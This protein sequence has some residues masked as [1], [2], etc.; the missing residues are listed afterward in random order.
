MKHSI[1][2]TFCLALVFLTG[3]ALAQ[4][5]DA[6][7]DEN[8]SETTSTPVAHVYVGTGNQ[9]EAFSAAL[10]GKL[11][12]VP[13]SPFKYSLLLQGANDHYLFG[14]EPSSVII[15]SFAMAANGALKMAV[16]T[17][18]ENFYS[19]DCGELTYWNGQG[20]R[21]DHSGKDLYNAAITDYFTCDNTFQSFKIDDTDGELTFLGTSGGTLLGGYRL[22]ILGNNQYAYSPS[23]N[24]AFG[25]S[26]YPIVVPFKRVSNGELVS[27]NAGV[28]IPAPPVDEHTPWGTPT[29][30]YYCPADVATDPTNHVAI[31]LYALTQTAG[32]DGGNLNYGPVV[33]ASYTADAKGNLT[34]TSTY[35]NMPTLPM[36]PE[37]TCLACSTLRMSPSGKLLAAGGPGGVALFHFNGGEPA[38]K[39]KTLLTSD[40]IGQILWDNHNHMY[41]I[42]SDSK[43]NGK[44]WV[45]TVTPTSVTEAP[46]SPYSITNPGSMV[47]HNLP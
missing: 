37:D 13:G 30:G 26:P 18:T 19:S 12:P 16:S 15:D 24:A 4:P 29:P 31:T 21:I 36:G 35:K 43:G 6:Q 9:I 5:S 32:E 3:A 42:G 11:T 17:N 40:G 20:L 7:T 46:G 39:Y 34:T 14:F 28:S 23:C 45:Y 38:T 22:G 1:R 10:N 44:L 27:T 33:I 8:V 41:A 25:N 2:L 47:V